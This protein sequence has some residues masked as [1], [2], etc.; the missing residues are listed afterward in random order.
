MNIDKKTEEQ[1]QVG[2]RTE[3]SMKVLL[4]RIMSGKRKEVV[5]LPERLKKKERT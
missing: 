3:H 1:V 2:E 5:N 4:E